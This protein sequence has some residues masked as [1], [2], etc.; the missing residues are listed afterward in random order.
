MQLL[1]QVLQSNFFR[2]SSAFGGSNKSHSRIAGSA[3]MRDCRR[4]PPSWGSATEDDAFPDACAL[5]C[6]LVAWLSMNFN[7]VTNKS[8]ASL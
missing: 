7:L 8:F 2:L 5:L 6:T 3:G 1:S 4:T